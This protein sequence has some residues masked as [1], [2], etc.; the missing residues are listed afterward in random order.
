MAEASIP[1][2]LFNPGQVFACIGILEVADILCGDAEGGFDWSNP[3]HVQFRIRANGELNPIEVTLRFLASAKVFALVPKSEQLSTDR[4]DVPMRHIQASQPFPCPPPSTPAAL[5]CALVGPH[6]VVPTCSVTV[7]I[8]HWGD[9]KAKTSRDNAKFWAGSGGYPGAALARDALEL[10]RDRLLDC[11]DDPFSCAAPQTSSFRLD[12]RR[13]Y[14][15]KNIGFSPNKH[16][17]GYIMPKGYPIVE[18]LGA[19]GLSNA[20]PLFVSRLE[21]RYGVL[22]V[23]PQEELYCLAFM[24]AALGILDLPF[25]QRRFRMLL[26]WPGKENQARCITNITEDEEQ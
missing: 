8:D 14:V 10:V 19:L 6:P 2:D 24:R 25:E 11:G 5:P 22:S 13:D 1:V 17:K 4:W 26:E 16:P 3:A 12:W 9:D 23:S 21:Y 15:D 7:L 20:R 18:L